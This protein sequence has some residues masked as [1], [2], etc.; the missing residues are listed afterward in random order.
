MRS[1][2]ME[3]SLKL[4]LGVFAETKL[5]K[6]MRKSINHTLTTSTDNCSF[7][8]LDCTGS[9]VTVQ[10]DENA[11]A[12]KCSCGYFQRKGIPCSHITAVK[13][14]L[15]R[16]VTFTDCIQRWQIGD[17][18][19]TSTSQEGPTTTTTHRTHKYSPLSLTMAVWAQT[20]LY[21]HV[22]QS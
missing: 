18:P 12:C 13:Q 17:E 2:S 9:G 3:K 7:A 15:G 20:D 1:K 14:Q 22:Q 6:Q 11:S 21:Q 4:T 16:P 5:I 8:I 10:T 19:S